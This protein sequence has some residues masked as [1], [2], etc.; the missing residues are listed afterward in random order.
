M[1]FRSAYLVLIH[2]NSFSVTGF[3]GVYCH[4]VEAR[5]YDKQ[6]RDNDLLVAKTRRIFNEEKY[7]VASVS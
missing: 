7:N 5:V 3:H 1:L 6:P 4:N 2:V